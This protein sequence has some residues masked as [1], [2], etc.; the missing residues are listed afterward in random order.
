M[1]V[2]LAYPYLTTFTIVNKFH[3]GVEVDALGIFTT[4]GI[5][6]HHE[7]FKLFITFANEIRERF[8]GNVVQVWSMAVCR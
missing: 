6:F 2:Q 4:S 8:A 5:M 1:S 3:Q 7:C